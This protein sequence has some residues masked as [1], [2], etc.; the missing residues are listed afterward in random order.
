MLAADG[1]SLVL[2]GFDLTILSDNY[3]HVVNTS[4]FIAAVIIL[5]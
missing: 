4:W 1:G 5:H 2:K 3:W